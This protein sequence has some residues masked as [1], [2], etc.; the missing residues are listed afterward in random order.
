MSA[1]I[2]NAFCA[3]MGERD[4]PAVEVTPG[5]FASDIPVSLA[6]AAHAGTSFSPDVR[7]QQVRAGYSQ[8]LEGL[9]DV[10]VKHADTEE[11]LATLAEEFDE[12]VA[13]NVNDDRRPV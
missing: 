8:E 9:W 3:V 10:L 11:K 6:Y 12:P 5:R 13:G 1:G 2:V 4:N 7:A